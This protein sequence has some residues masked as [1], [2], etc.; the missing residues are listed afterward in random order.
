MGPTVWI[1]A[2]GWLLLLSLLS[3][4]LLLLLLLLLKDDEE[5]EERLKEGVILAALVGQPF[6]ERQYCRRYGPA[7]RWM[8]PSTPP[9]PR[10]ESVLGLDNGFKILVFHF[11]FAFSFSF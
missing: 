2:R 8:A 10:R 3:M 4:L 1:M 11:H 9:P 7:A 5:G 6:R